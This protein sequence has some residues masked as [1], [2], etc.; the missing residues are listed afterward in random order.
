MSAVHVGPKMMTINDCT[1]CNWVMSNFKLFMYH[2]PLLINTIKDDF[3]SL[4]QA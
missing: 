1:I 2:I 3:M 4:S